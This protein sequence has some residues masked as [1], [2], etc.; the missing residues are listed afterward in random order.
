MRYYL[1]ILW[2]LVGSGAWC[3]GQDTVS[4][5]VTRVDFSTLQEQ[6]ASVDPASPPLADT[7]A[8]TSGIPQSEAPLVKQEA[9][10]L[11]AAISPDRPQQGKWYLAGAAYWAGLGGSLAGMTMQGLGIHN[12]NINGFA[13]GSLLYLLSTPVLGVGASGLHK[14]AAARGSALESSSGWY[15]YAGSWAFTL[16]GAILVAH[17]ESSTA[18]TNDADEDRILGGGALVAGVLCHYAST[19]SFILDG[20]RSYASYGKPPKA[21]PVLYPE[22]GVTA[23]GALRPGMRWIAGW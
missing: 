21:G 8:Q 7:S 1:K 15:L 18:L 11:P 16:F 4:S 19:V 5:A 3:W 6:S 22:L 23:S 2:L 20:K 13:Q 14:V 17:A 12:R 9:G 10:S